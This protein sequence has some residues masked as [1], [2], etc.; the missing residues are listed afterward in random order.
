[1]HKFQ[2]RRPGMLLALIL[3]LGANPA[4]GHETKLTTLQIVHPW[5][6]GYAA[7]GP[8]APRDVPLFMTLLNTGA[9]TDRLI[10]VSS[11]LAAGAELR[12]AG[13]LA[14]GIELAPGATLKMVRTG[15]HVV[16]HGVTDDLAGYE[17]FPVWLT[18]EKAG[19]VEVAAV[20][21]DPS[22]MDPSC[23][24]SLVP[25]MAKHDHADHAS[26]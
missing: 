1:M 9:S 2:S 17:A 6:H 5:A 11:P 18:F 24:G 14:S 15:P 22:V 13:D 7:T 19:R 8:T 25:S 4:S 21:E 3:A 16:L 26:H 23:T 10:A 12:L 20:V